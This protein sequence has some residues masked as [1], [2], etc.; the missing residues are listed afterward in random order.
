MSQKVS[1]AVGRR[2]VAKVLL[3]DWHPVHACFEVS[4]NAS[5]HFIFE[6]FIHMKSFAT[7]DHRSVCTEVKGSV[8]QHRLALSAIGLLQTGK[9]GGH[10]PTVSYFWHNCSKMSTVTTFIIPLCASAQWTLC[11]ACM[12]ESEL[13]D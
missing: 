8:V 9:S 4:F 5:A 11:N 13:Q 1:P 10:L 12:L 6:V 3:S 7:S 2:A